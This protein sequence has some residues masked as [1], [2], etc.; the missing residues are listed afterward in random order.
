MTFWDVF[1][2]LLIWFPIFLLWTS[3]LFDI[4]RR[5]D[6]SG[7]AIFGWMLL[8]FVLPI[9]GSLIYFIARP[10]AAD[11]SGLGYESQQA[12]GVSVA[13]ALVIGGVLRASATLDKLAQQGTITQEEFNRQ[14]ARLLA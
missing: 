2:L 4:L 8:I 13:E 3:A 9:I 14:K 6:L 1:F 12:T 10:A 11:A 7:W 5:N